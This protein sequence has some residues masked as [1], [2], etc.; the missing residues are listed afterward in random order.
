MDLELADERLFFQQNT[1]RFLERE[2]S[3][4]RVRELRDTEH[5]YDPAWWRRA[6]ELGWTS[7]LASEDAGGGSLSGNPVSDAVIVAEELGRAVG[8]GPFLPTNVV[9]SALGDSEY[10]PGLLD[11][12][13]TAAW[14]LDGDCEARVEGDE[15]VLNGEKTHVEAGASADVVL[16]VAGSVQVLVPRDHPG[17]TVIPGRSLD[18]VRR[19]ARLVF[20]DVRV[21]R[22]AVL[23]G[24]DVERQLR[25][26]LTLQ[27]AESV[28][29][30]DRVFEFTFAYLGDRYAFGRPIASYQALKHRVA[31]MLLHLESAKATTDAAARALDSDDP[32]AGRLVRIAAAYVGDTAPTFVQ[33]C[34]QLLGGIGQT[35]EHD[36]HLYLRRATLNRAVF[37]T[38]EQHREQIVVRLG[39]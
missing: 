11:G 20:D 28:G 17:V 4:E 30:M 16:V 35:W 36:I 21:P 34:V 32:E 5:G 7:L 10:L 13:T 26:A 24:A 19:F 1:R 18:L 39:V 38:P 12:S 2:A 31:D 37:G 14:A 22:S 9:V 27:S 8:P 15:V 3:I 23:E 29:V 33:E 25:L 6:A